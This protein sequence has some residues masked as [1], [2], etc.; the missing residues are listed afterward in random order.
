V[1]R[2]RVSIALLCRVVPRIQKAIMSA[3]PSPMMPSLSASDLDTPTP[4][5][6]AGVVMQERG[7]AS[8]NPSPCVKRGRCDDA[9]SEVPRPLQP[10]FPKPSQ[11][12]DVSLPPPPKFLQFKPYP[13]PP[14]PKKYVVGPQQQGHN[15]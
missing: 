11:L 1:P 9:P 3:A 6:A 7:A 10:A 12:G 4:T 2:Q 5:P 8:A 13:P 15:S 14:P